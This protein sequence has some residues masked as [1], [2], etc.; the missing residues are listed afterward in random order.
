MVFT[1]ERVHESSPNDAP[2]YFR[3]L[4]AYLEVKKYITGDVLEVGCGDAYGT[5]L[6]VPLA[7]T[8]TA[9]DKFK[10]ENISKQEGVNFIQMNVPPFEVLESNSFDTIISFQVIEHIEDDKY[11]LKEIQ[12][13]LKPGGKFIFTT[14]N[15]KMS[16]TRNPYHIREY[17]MS[18]Y[19]DLCSVFG[20]F[21]L[22]GVFGDEKVMEYFEKNKESVRKITRFDIFN[23]QYRL[24]RAVLKVPY[25]LANA[26]NRKNLAEENTAL[27]QGIK[28]DNYFLADATEVC[29]DFFCIAE[30]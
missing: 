22:K 17:I 9:V 4:F 30:K 8:Y 11:F 23:L 7:K 3:Q 1:A 12:R 6:L 25:D 27:T 10:S 16:L 19:K 28:T 24:P 13:L 5:K 20:G 14:P 15:K 18:E 21:E 26:L 29:L 2:V